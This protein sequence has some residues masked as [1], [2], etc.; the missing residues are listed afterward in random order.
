MQQV[1]LAVERDNPPPP[2]PPWLKLIR[3]NRP[4]EQRNETDNDNEKYDDDN[5]D[6][7]MMW[8]INCGGKG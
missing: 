1:A 5:D 3:S 7:E 4:R 2:L 6:A 8:Q